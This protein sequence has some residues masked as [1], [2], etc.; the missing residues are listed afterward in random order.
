MEQIRFGIIGMG[1]WN[2]DVHIPNLL[3]IPE[4]AITAISSR[5][6][7]NLDR[8]EKAIGHKVKRYTDY[9][10][11][12]SDADI[13]AVLVGTPDHT[14]LTVAGDALDSAKHIF[15]EKPLATS[16]DDCKALTKKALSKPQIFQVGFEFRYSD[17]Y[18]TI[19]KMIN[20]GD[21]GKPHMV[22]SKL[23]RGPFLPK[24]EMWSRKIENTGGVL[25]SLGTHWFD[26][27]NGLAGSHPKNAM[28]TG[29]T[30]V[31]KEAEILDHATAII[32]YEEEL[33]AVVMLCMFSPFNNDLEIGIIGEEGKIVA[34]QLKNCLTVDSRQSPTQ[35][36][37]QLQSPPNYKE[38]MFFGTRKILEDFI[39]N[40]QN[41]RPPLTDA[42]AGESA[43]LAA[44]TAEDAIRTGSKV[45]VPELTE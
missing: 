38:A 10:D 31:N 45:P 43:S 19:L 30:S 40:I 24:P 28:G 27:F 3:N 21:I 1:Y 2:L 25:N 29:G 32:E 17:M 44:L 37:I 14:H 12:L 18:K 9:Q 20:D 4:A 35:H 34:S 6:E 41:N 33:H 7:E 5:K 22:W 13:D 11:M 36:T 26:M 23:F 39:G 8:G 42:R 15:C 16:V